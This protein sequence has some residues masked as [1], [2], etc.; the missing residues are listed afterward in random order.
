MS[1]E[2]DAP[3]VAVNKGRSLA[4]WRWLK[5]GLPALALSGVFATTALAGGGGW[6]HG[7]DGAPTQEQREKFMEKRL[8]RMLEHLNATPQQETQIK[9][10]FAN[11]KAQ[12]QAM[13]QERKQLHES[14]RALMTAPNLDATAV[15]GVRSK[16]VAQADKSSRVFAEVALQ[17]GQ[18]L[19]QAQ[20][21][22]LAEHMAHGRGHGHGPGP[23]G[24]FGF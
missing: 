6:G 24:P 11:H 23:G 7:K 16:M 8:S 12:M 5:V 4:G 17:V 22:Q 14:M 15:E 13:H 18:I 10:V 19:T 9:A 3:K 2:N 1:Y 20:R 21:Q